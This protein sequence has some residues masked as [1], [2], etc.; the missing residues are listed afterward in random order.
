MYNI[1]IIHKLWL[2]TFTFK[3][4]Q[5]GIVN[6]KRTYIDEYMHIYTYINIFQRSSRPQD[7]S[8]ILMTMNFV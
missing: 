4:K 8:N 6:N 5:Y 7:P 1:T 3:Y 2:H